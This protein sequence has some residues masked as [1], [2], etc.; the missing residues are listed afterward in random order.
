MIQTPLKQRKI[1]L[2]QCPASIRAVYHIT[3]LAQKFQQSSEKLLPHEKNSRISIDK[4]LLDDFDLYYKI[5]GGQFFEPEYSEY[6]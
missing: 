4:I 2:F 5:H 6:R 1:D 3:N